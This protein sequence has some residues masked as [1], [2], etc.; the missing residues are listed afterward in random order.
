MAIKCNEYVYK[1]QCLYAGSVT[2][3]SELNE[4]ALIIATQCVAIP[5]IAFVQNQIWKYAIREYAIICVFNRSN[6]MSF[7][8]IH[9]YLFIYLFMI[10]CMCDVSISCIWANRTLIGRRTDNEQMK[11]TNSWQ[12]LNCSAAAAATALDG[13]LGISST[14]TGTRVACVSVFFCSS[15]NDVRQSTQLKRMSKNCPKRPAYVYFFFARIRVCGNVETSAIKSSSLSIGFH[16]FFVLLYC[17]WVDCIDFGLY[18]ENSIHGA[19][20]HIYRKLFFIFVSIWKFGRKFQVQAI[21]KGTKKQVLNVSTWMDGWMVRFVWIWIRK[22]NV[23]KSNISV[24]LSF[25]HDDIIE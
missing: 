5:R 1:C 11:W 21:S 3:K 17:H 6:F 10:R 8:S 14:R 2:M 16:I 4:N 19:G 22:T 7:R 23:N 12:Y 13:N 9:L 15:E 18:L 24:L 20:G 25:E